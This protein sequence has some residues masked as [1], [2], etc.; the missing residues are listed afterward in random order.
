MPNTRDLIRFALGALLV[1]LV[2]RGTAWD[3]VFR[4]IRSAHSAPLLGAL[5]VAACTQLIRAQRGAYVVRAASDA[6]Y[7]TIYSSALIGIFLN[8]AL[9]LRAGDAARALVLSKGIPVPGAKAVSMVVVDRIADLI[10]LLALVGIVLAVLPR[11]L[12]VRAIPIPWPLIRMTTWAGVALVITLL[13]ILLFLYFDPA[14]ALR[15]LELVA[16][17]LP[18]D[19]QT[20]LGRTVRDL[21]GGLSILRAPADIA[22]TLC[23]AFL[24]WLSAC[25]TIHLVLV[26]FGLDSSWYSALLMQ[27]LVALSVLVPLVPGL[28]GQYHLPIIAGLLATAPET[29]LPE[30]KAVAVVAHLAAVIPIAILGGAALLRERLGVRRIGNETG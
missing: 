18:S 14:R 21:A 9:P 16:R 6:R 29:G 3:E 13:A 25:G 27:A 22:K 1:W 30:A 24:A 4:A 15:L 11:D 8:V 5:A 12:A 26:A 2:F 19:L 28:I 7:S 23:F 10:G 17:P 20:K